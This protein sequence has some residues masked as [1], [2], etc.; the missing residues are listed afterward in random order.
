MIICQEKVRDKSEN[1][2]GGISKVSEREDVLVS[3]VI[4]TYSRSDT[5]ERALNGILKQTYQNLDIIVVDDN[6]PNS[7]YRLFVQQIIKK[8][9]SDQRIR[10]IQN[11]QNLGGAG[12]RNVG[13]EAAKGEYIAFLD[14]DDEYYPE[15]IE[16]QLKVFLNSDSDKLALV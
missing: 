12:A 7:V 9:A 15:K 4:P 10:Y 1:N 8:Y 16:K 3:V 13:I 14:D 6:P 5:L 2:I 11:T